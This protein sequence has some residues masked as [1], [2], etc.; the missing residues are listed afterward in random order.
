MLWSY[1]QARLLILIL[2]V[3]TLFILSLRVLN[4]AKAEGID[5][6]SKQAF[7]IDATTNAVLLSKNSDQPMPPAS[8]S[9]L[10]TI[11]MVFDRLKQGRL[12][13]D[14]KFEV[15]EKAWRKGGSK[16]F[17]MVNTRVKVRDLLRGIIVQSGNDACIVVAEGISGSERAFADAM[18]RKAKD[19]GLTNSSFSN[20]TGWPAKDHY[21]TA[22]DIAIL[23]AKLITEFPEYY[24]IFAEKNFSWGQINQG[25]R[26]PL[27]YKN[28]GADGLKTGYTAASGY[29]LA[30]SVVRKGRRLIMVVNGLTSKRQ[31]ASESLRLLDWGFR[32]TAN[33]A[34][35]KKGDTIGYADVWLGEQA[36]VPMIAEHSVTVTL[37][38]QAR[39]EMKVKVIYTKPIPA[40]LQKGNVIGKVIITAP[41]RPNIELAAVAGVSVNKLGVFGRLKAAFNYL[42]WGK[43]DTATS[44]LRKQNNE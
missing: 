33:Y 14:D 21:M 11:Y 38:R 32:E 3:L 37:S 26:N 39:Q 9:K 13:L 8:M 29:G 44:L 7:M 35:F 41:E 23:S 20:S 24:Q 22:R 19:I 42:L 40:P 18:A 30:A 12:S 1:N 36:R 10:M 17:V 6:L 16:M 15:S 2:T 28:Y 43:S 5:T 27:L 25:N 34:L 4:L 31:R